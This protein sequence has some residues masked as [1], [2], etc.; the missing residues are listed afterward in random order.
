MK[1]NCYNEAEIRKKNTYK[2]CKSIRKRKR[3]TIGTVIWFEFEMR[4]S[5]ITVMNIRSL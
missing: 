4:D 3:Q 2:S 1:P 5:Y